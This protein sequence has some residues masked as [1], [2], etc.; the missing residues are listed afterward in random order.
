MP[1][2]G[3]GSG[4]TTRRRPVT[5]RQA[6]VARA[7]LAAG[8]LPRQEQR[9]LRKLVSAQNL[10]AR[11]RELEMRQLVLAVAGAVAAMAI[12]AAAFALG[13]AIDAARGQ[14]TTG[15][16]VVGE[17]VCIKGCTWVGTFESASGVVLPSVAY[18]GSLP[19]GAGPG[20]RIPAIDPGGSNR[21]F[22]PR[23]SRVWVVDVLITLLAGCAVGVCLWIFPIP[24]GRRQARGS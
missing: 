8:D 17:M 2:L 21:V 20:S 18:D 7:K 16:F 11:R 23:G 13:P 10:A 1:V 6:R 19:E 24:V 3:Q 14:G 15:T 9:R 4:A 12:V 5:R 22:A